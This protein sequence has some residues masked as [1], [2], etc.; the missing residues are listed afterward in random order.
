ME[1]SK[2]FFEKRFPNLRLEK[3]YCHLKD[4][5]TFPPCENDRRCCLTCEKIFECKI[6]CSKRITQ[7]QLRCPYEMEEGEIAMHD[8]RRMLIENG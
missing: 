7:Q 1:H 6:S 3:T 2:T 8:L 5:G 4:D